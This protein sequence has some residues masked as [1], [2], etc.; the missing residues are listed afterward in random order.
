MEQPHSVDIWL[1]RLADIDD[2]MRRAYEDLLDTSEKSRLSRF[3]ASHA[4]DQYLIA[5]ALLRTALSCHADVPRKAWRFG[6]NAHGKPHIIAP[7]IRVPLRF[8]LSHTQD[9]IACA[10]SHGLELGVDI[11]YVPY[12]QDF[13]EVVPM[14]LAPAEAAELNLLRPPARRRRFYTLW[15]LKEAY[16][17]AVGTGLSVPLDTLQFHPDCRPLRIEFTSNSAEEPA[18]WHFESLFPTPEHALA[19]AVAADPGRPVCVT[20][21]WTVPAA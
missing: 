11:E 7:D 1:A 14:V 2:G 18:H 19:L 21:H 13:L 6:S 10:V 5:R 16:L 20:M 8:N 17:K 9:A 15:T 3:I 4:R 12:D